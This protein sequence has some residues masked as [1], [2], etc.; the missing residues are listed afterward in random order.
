MKITPQT[1]ELDLQARPPVARTAAEV[2]K[3]VAEARARGQ[4]IGF[5][6]T[7]GALHAGH[8]S[9]IE[10][11]KRRDAFVVVSIYVNPTQFAPQEDLS[12]YPRPFADDHRKCAD[13]AVDLVFAPTDETMYPPGDETRVQPGALATG[14]CG[15]HRPGHFEGV[16]TVVA[17][18]FNLVA[19][20]F[21]CFGQKDAQQ[22]LI[23]QRMVTDLQYPIEIVI[24]PTLREPD[25]LALSSRNTYLSTDERTQAL[26]LYNA[27][28]SGR[29][30]LLKGGAAE[31]AT[32]V[33][34]DAIATSLTADAIDYLVAV[35]AT[36]LQ[37]VTATTRRVLLVGAIRIGKTRLIDNLLVDL[38]PQGT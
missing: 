10:H 35:D 27:L 23:I 34:T 19:P 4:T 32:T 5:V 15:P 21:A 17:R 14:L 26:C 18:L 9:L 30:T 7:M 37:A 28:T 11:A 22:A 29:E 31:H 24:C 38:P 20:D 6:P 12:S 2:R 25:G 36:N 16:C 33:M 13:A 3:K 8:L 1:T